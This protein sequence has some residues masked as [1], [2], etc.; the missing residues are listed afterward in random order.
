MKAI[1]VIIETP[2]GSTEKYSFEP[3]KN[4]FKLK[5]ILPAG[6]VFPYDFGFIPNTKGDDGDPLDVMVLSEY[7]SFPGCM[8]ECNII[9]AIIAE[10]SAEDGMVRN[11]RYVAVCTLSNIYKHYKSIED[12]PKKMLEQLE[13]FFVTYNKAEG[14]KFKITKIVKAN[15]AHKMLRR[16]MDGI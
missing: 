13:L 4:L 11:D 6:M 2:K 5:K 15:T 10:Q 1:E 8:V 3:M 14:K 12:F 16:N 7:K 9:G